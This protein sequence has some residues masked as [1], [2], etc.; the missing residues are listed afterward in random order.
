MKESLNKFQNRTQKESRTIVDNLEKEL[1]KV[2]FRLE[3]EGKLN[4]TKDFYGATTRAGK[5]RD[6]PLTGRLRNSINAQIKRDQNTVQVALIAGRFNGGS[7]LEY[8]AR[9]E[10][11]DPKTRLKPFFYLGRAVQ[12][13]QT[14]IEKDLSRFLKLELENL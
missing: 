7:I 2:R 12:K 1:L 9:L 3:R 6:Y 4:A 11:G 5:I 14:R 10:F 13:E 8:A